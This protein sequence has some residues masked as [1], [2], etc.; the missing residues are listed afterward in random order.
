MWYFNVADQSAQMVD[1]C[2]QCCCQ[3]ISLKPGTTSK[4]TIG[5]ATWSIPIG[6]LHCIPSFVLDQM[7]TCPVAPAG[8]NLPPRPA[9]K[10]AFDTAM[11]TTLTDDLSTQV[12][13]PEGDPLTFKW[14]MANGPSHG[15]L[16]LAADGSFTYVPDTTYVGADRF[17]ASVS[18]GINP[19]VVFEIIVG[20]GTPSADIASTPSVGVDPNG[21]QID[22]RMHTVSF[23][24]KISPAAQLCEVWRLSM[25]QNAIDC[26]CYCYNRTD[27]YDIRIAK[28]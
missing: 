7:Q 13:D 6:R 20:V 17:F 19:A 23:P 18:D 26:D 28:C 4:V 14:L 22:Y 16:T 27:C 1:G 24:I 3:T 12:T 25:A 5:Y 2:V 15:K 11:N 10:V 8:A 21:V 9:S